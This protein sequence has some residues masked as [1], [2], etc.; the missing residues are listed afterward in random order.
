VEDCGSWYWTA[1]RFLGLFAG[2][3]FGISGGAFLRL[4]VAI[5]FALQIQEFRLV[6]EPIDEGHDAAGI[7]EDLGPFAEGFVGGDNDGVFLV[8]ARTSSV[9]ARKYSA[10]PL[11]TPMR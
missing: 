9:A 11:P 2:A 8:A 6:H 10:S 1:S 7:R 5:A 3:G 4:F